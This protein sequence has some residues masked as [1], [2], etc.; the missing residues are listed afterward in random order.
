[1]MER[2]SEPGICRTSNL[3]VVSNQENIFNAIGGHSIEKVVKDPRI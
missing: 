3:K 2:E 1:M